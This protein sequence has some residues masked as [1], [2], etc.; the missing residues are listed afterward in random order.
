MNYILDF[1]ASTTGGAVVPGIVMPGPGLGTELQLRVEPRITF[2]LHGY[3]VNRENGRASLLRLAA[4]LS[5]SQNEAVV[6]VLW[7]G[8]HWTRAVSYSFEGRDAD[9]SAQALAE[10][11]KTYITRSTD[12]SFVSHSLG[13]R[14]VME[15]IKRLGAYRIRQV[16]LM[17]PAIDDSSLA[18][19]KVYQVAAGGADRVAVLA[20]RKDNTLRYAYPA[21]DALQAFI[22]FWK[23]VVDLALGYH[24]PRRSKTFEIPVKVYAVQIPDERS[25]DHGHYIPGNPLEDVAGDPAIA[26]RLSAARFADEVLRGEAAPK[27]I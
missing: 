6:A 12:I 4:R 8:D 10:Y 17:A 16:V 7:P 25:S 11:V 22:F 3:N 21:G 2:L 27:Y 14:V 5:A 13:A 20:S 18:N 15:T 1:R 23:D 19:P 9:D 26:N 24:G